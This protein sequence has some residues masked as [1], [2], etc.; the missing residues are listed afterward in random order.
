GRRYM[1]G[2]RILMWCAV[3][4][5]LL[6]AGGAGGAGK[7]NL[8]F[9]LCDGLGDG[10]GSCYHPQGKIKTPHMDRLAAEGLRFTDAHTTSSVCTPT[11]YSLLTGRYA[12]RTR[13]Q[14]G[15]LGGLS[16][17]LIEPGRLT[18]GELLQRQGYQTAVVGKWHLGLDWVRVPGRPAPP[19][20][21]IE[22][23]EHHGSVDYLLPIAR[24]P[25]QAGFHEFF[26]I[27][28]SLDM[29]PYTF[30]LNDR[31]ISAPTVNKRFPMMPGRTNAFTRLGP[32][33]PEFRADQVLP[34]LTRHAVAWIGQQAEAARAGRPFFLY[35]ALASPHTPIVPTKPWQGRSGLNPYADFV[36]QTDDAVGQVLAALDRH[37]LATNTLV[38]LTSDNGCAPQADVKALREAGHE[39]SGPWRGYKADIW[40]GGHRVPFIVRW[41]GVT[42]AGATT[43]ELVSLVDFLATCAELLG[44]SLPPKAGEDSL[45]F[46]PVLRGEKGRRD[47]LVCHSINGK[48]ALRERQWKL[49]LTPGSGGWSEPRDEAARQQGLPEVQLYDLAGDPGET[50][51]LWREHPEVVERLTRR[52]EQVVQEG[53]STPGP[54][55]ANAVPVDIWKRP[56]KPA[57]APKVEPR[58]AAAPASGSPTGGAG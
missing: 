53:R 57:G 22:T 28:G 54:R 24:G 34:E 23:A 37:G 25:L 26:G 15:V 5:G 11:R 31:V 7:P 6:V 58:P 1:Q 13:L 38:I 56:A 47:T 2:M 40:E 12:W 14:T 33:A 51:N 29:V 32:G 19:A 39:P 55:Q 17:S 9:I 20:N 4:A 36:L 48:F 46:L 27:A 50:R 42:P 16:P 49:C 10:D 18:V 35:L 3:L 21:G 8:V 43:G 30:I 52:L 44:V 41:P 45:S